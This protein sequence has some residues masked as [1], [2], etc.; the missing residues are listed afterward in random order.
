MICLCFHFDSVGQ[1]H[2]QLAN[3][4]TSQTEL[5]SGYLVIVTPT[6]T[7]ESRDV[8]PTSSKLIFCMQTKL[9]K[10][11]EYCLGHFPMLYECPHNFHPDICLA[12]ICPIFW[13]YKLFIKQ[14]CSNPKLFWFK[15]IFWNHYFYP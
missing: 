5:L 12:D 4:V 8:L 13:T 6:N 11:D 1:A 9:T 7:Q 10:K 2:F 15:N 14:N 3:I